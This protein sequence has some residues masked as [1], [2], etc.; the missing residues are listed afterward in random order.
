MRW[1]TLAEIYTMHSFAPFGIESQKPR[2]SWGEKNLDRSLSSIFCQNVFRNFANFANIFAK[3]KTKKIRF[4][5]N[6]VE[7]FRDYAKMQFSNYSRDSERYSR[8]SWRF[9]TCSSSDDPYS[10]VGCRLAPPQLLRSAE[11]A[12]G[13]AAPRDIRVLGPVT[14]P[15]S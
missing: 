10:P 9:R 1:K 8:D 4:L 6:V 3:E 12:A 7:K 2:K 13:R 14:L 5:L 15:M 11:S